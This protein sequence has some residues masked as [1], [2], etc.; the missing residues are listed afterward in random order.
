MCGALSAVLAPERSTCV[1]CEDNPKPVEFQTPVCSKYEPVVPEQ[2]VS[3]AQKHAHF[4][5]A[6]VHMDVQG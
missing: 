2:K 6:D 4:P 1:A 5:E 3:S